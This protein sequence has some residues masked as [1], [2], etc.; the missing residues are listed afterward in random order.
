ME[1]K[2]MHKKRNI[3]LLVLFITWTLSY[4]DRMVMTVAIPYIAKDFNLTPVDMG[5]V[6]SAFFA[7][8]ALFQIPGG[9][10]ADKFGPR[11]TMAIAISWWSIFTGLTAMVSNLTSMLVVRVL[12]GIGEASFP[13]GS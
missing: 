7:G 12:F 5:V 11:K 13:G 10:L 9:L 2:Y 8:Y 3:I 4:M 1:G 6:M